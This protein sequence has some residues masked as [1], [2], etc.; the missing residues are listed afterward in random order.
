MWT[1]TVAATNTWRDVFANPQE[2][3]SDSQSA[4]LSRY[5]LLWS[6][7]TNSAFENLRNW[8]L[9]RENYN[10]YR[11]TR[12]I[13]NPTQR[14]VDFYVDHIYP[15][16]LSED[17]SR[18]PSG[19]QLA[20]PLA[21]DTSDKLKIAI[22]QLWQWSNWQDG[23]GLM[24]RYGGAI[25]SVL[26]EVMDEVERSK[27]TANVVYAGHVSEIET[28]STGNVQFYALEYQAIDDDEQ[29]YTYRKE[30]DQESFRTFKNDAPFGFNGQ[31]AEYENPY[32]FVPAVWIKHINQGGDYGVPALRGSIGKI[33]ELNSL[34]AHLNDHIHNLIKNP[35]LIGSSGAIS[36]LF[37]GKAGQATEVQESDTNGRQSQIFLKGPADV[38]VHK[39]SGNIDL[40]K[41]LPYL[42]ELL[43]EIE[44]D[45]PELTFYQELREMS[46]VTGPAAARLTGDVGNR[47]VK[48]AA[49]Y[50]LQ[51]IK[52]FQMMTAI[53]GWRLSTGAWAMVSRQQ[54][55][56][57][58]FDLTSYAKGDLD[59][60]IVP[61]QLITLTET[62][63]IANDKARA[64]AVNLKADKIS[65]N[66]WFREMGYSEEDMQLIQ[67]EKASLDVVPLEVQ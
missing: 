42:K 38:G 49:Q 59:F 19:V 17:G 15:G 14:L 5:A 45:F 66:Q 2:P 25:G 22:S 27:V 26:V 29:A 52:L 61:R 53:A 60:A 46:Q 11:Y 32:G 55:K 65:D 34:A 8:S 47:V 16:V 58:P 37:K 35:I 48:A 30:V 21:D 41:A 33:D 57:R 62:E 56:F 9:Y 50:D 12:S 3:L 43:T 67:S 20:I 10:L 36:S 23:C 1:A 44:H 18:L 6:Y 39:L 40:D 54:E 13:Y 63:A 4:R 51:S 31:P 24:V 7:Y 28:D 64:E